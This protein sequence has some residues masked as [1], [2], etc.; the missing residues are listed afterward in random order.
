VFSC[1]SEE[2]SLEQVRLLFLLSG[3]TWVNSIPFI[4]K[5]EMLSK[6]YSGNIIAPIADEKWSGDCAVGKFKIHGFHVYWGNGVIRS[7]YYTFSTIRKAIKLFRSI[8][9][10]DVIIS[11][12]PLLTG[13]IAVFL[14][15]LINAKTVVEVNGNFEA[16]FAFGRTGKADPEL[17]ERI[18]GVVSKIMI[19]FV[20]RK[21]SIVKLVYRN[22]LKP[23]GLNAEQHLRTVSFPNFVPVESFIH[24]D[25]GDDQYILLL[26]YPWFL[27]GVDIL[28]KAFKLV[29]DE[30]PSYRLRIVGWC[31]EGKE[32]YQ[33]LA[34]N[35]PSISLE[36]PVYYDDVIRLMT[37]CSLY[38]LASRTDSSPRV[39][40]EAMASRKPIIASNIDGVP[41][42]IIDGYNG[43]LFEKENVA[44]LAAKIK[45]VLSNPD[46]ADRLA[47]N[48]LKY[49]R[50]NLSED[51]YLDNYA[52]LLARILPNHF[53]YTSNH[54]V[55]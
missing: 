25:S 31:P 12:N 34:G 46:I 48:G 22:Q 13:L 52:K 5:F 47:G 30:F 19:S 35:D 3:P 27:K 40:R 38:V 8:E 53:Q 55:G 4:T 18:K 36:D 43:L 7:L 15:W 37:H 45:F 26:G 2:E 6:A 9:R 23:L 29:S 14:A 10:P 32:Y 42:L 11:P 44:D 28:I 17:T 50:E 20:V 49:V 39:L 1:I 21:A 33:D 16:A 54:V 24:A 41:D 51:I